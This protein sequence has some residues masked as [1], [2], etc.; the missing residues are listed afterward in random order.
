MIGTMIYDKSAEESILLSHLS[1]LLDKARAAVVGELWGDY[2]S[3]MAVG[4]NSLSND[5]KARLQY[6]SQGV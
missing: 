5:L 6:A 4:R 1:D 3:W 2:I